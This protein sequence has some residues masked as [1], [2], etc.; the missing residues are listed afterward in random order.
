M[1]RPT[2]T[3]HWCTDAGCAVVIPPGLPS[4]CAKRTFTSLVSP[5]APDFTRSFSTRTGRCDPRYFGS[6]RMQDH[7]TVW[8]RLIG[9]FISPHS[10]R[11]SDVDFGIVSKFPCCHLRC[12]TTVTTC[13][14]S[15]IWWT[16]QSRKISPSIDKSSRSIGIF[17]KIIDISWSKILLK[18]HLACD[19]YR[20]FRR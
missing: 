8:V 7:A 2:T 1:M 13:H 18:C 15:I 19:N 20:V 10:V 14:G 9:Y 12:F 6:P 16:Y 17:Y 3:R 5:D 11:R 4:S